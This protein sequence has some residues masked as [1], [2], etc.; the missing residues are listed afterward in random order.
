MRQRYTRRYRNWSPRWKWSARETRW[1][2][3]WELQVRES[4]WQI[5]SSDELESSAVTTYPPPVCIECVHLTE[6]DPAKPEIVGRC[7]AF[8][9]GIP[10]H[11][12]FEAD[13]HTEPIAGDH[14]IRFESNEPV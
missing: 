4:D 8:P 6:P 14:G 2:E 11:V 13:P 12:W 10:H 5:A 3:D 7:E 9:T 1:L